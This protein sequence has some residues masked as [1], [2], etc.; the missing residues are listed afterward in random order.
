MIYLNDS[1]LNKIFQRKENSSTDAI[2]I[3]QK[4]EINA[5]RKIFIIVVFCVFCWLPMHILNIIST[6]TGSHVRSE[7][8][9]K[10]A[11]VLQHLSSAVDPILYAYHLKGFRRAIF[12]RFK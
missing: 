5:T 10:S 12:G 4:R 3:A 7:F 11:K 2:A 8:V 1:R 6:I 9:N